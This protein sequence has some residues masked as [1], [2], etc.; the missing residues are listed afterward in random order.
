MAIG[1]KRNYSTVFV[2]AKIVVSAAGVYVFIS[3]RDLSETVTRLFAI[4]CRISFDANAFFH[5]RVRI[6]LFIVYVGIIVALIYVRIGGIYAVDAGHGIAARHFRRIF[7]GMK[8]SII[9]IS[10]AALPGFFFL[11]HKHIHSQSDWTALQPYI[12]LI[13]I[14]SL[15]VLRNAH[16]A[17]RAFHS[18][19]FAWLGRYSGE[20]YVMQDHLWLA[21]DQE[22]VLHTGLFH[23][24][25][26]V[27]RDRWRDLLLLTPLYLIACCILGDATGTIVKYFTTQ[28]VSEEPRQAGNT[29]STGGVE[30]PLLSMDE[31]E[32]ENALGE[33]RRVQ[34]RVWDRICWPRRVGHRAFLVLGVMWVLNMVSSLCSLFKRIALTND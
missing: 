15:L 32:M 8:L 13:P 26:S 29:A 27:A 24:D 11:K 25:G 33:K 19:A 30:V 10:T 12:T 2:L 18:T 6:D 9:V 7:K 3:T 31:I 34:Q 22:A 14:L 20:M 5:Y 28:S 23:G 21:G 1:S 16:P 17:F 4:T